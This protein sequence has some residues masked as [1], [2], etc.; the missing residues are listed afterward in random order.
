M[1]P[2]DTAACSAS[3][4]TYRAPGGYRVSTAELDLKVRRSTEGSTRRIMP[5]N[6][7][8]WGLNQAL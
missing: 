4:V 2:W 3:V 1:S 5:S 6:G 8:Y 7:R